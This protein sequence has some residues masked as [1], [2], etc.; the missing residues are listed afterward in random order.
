MKPFINKL[1]LYTLLFVLLLV[2][3]VAAKEKKQKKSKAVV[4]AEE[5]NL[6]DV[7]SLPAAQSVPSDAE[8]DAPVPSVASLKAA[9]ELKKWDGSLGSLETNFEQTTS[10][11]TILI[12][13]SLGQLFYQKD[14][15]CLRLDTFDVSGKIGQSAVKNGND[16]TLLD[17]KGK[18]IADM[19][20]SDWQANQPNK[21]LFDFGNYKKLVDTHTT[22]IESETEKAI[23]LKLVPKGKEYNLY[24]ALS[25]EDYF[26]RAITIEAELMQTKAVLTNVKKNVNLKTGLFEGKK[27]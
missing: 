23:T 25:K 26:P 4:T 2:S 13:T 1:P 20:W 22:T 15:D 3:P 19:K 6:E 27:K 5:I 10:Y 8:T 9:E 14:C 17:E 24:I 7:E 18:K 16:L 12:S 11:D 21:A